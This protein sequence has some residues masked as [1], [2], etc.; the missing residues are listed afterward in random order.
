ME[1][2]GW[3]AKAIQLLKTSKEKVTVKKGEGNKDL[4]KLMQSQG[5][6]DYKYWPK[7]FLNGKFIGGYTDLEKKLTS[8]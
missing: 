4:A 7:I 5:R 8:N 3:C 2:C 1:G 6:A